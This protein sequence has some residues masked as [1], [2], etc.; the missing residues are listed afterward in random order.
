MQHSVHAL[1][2]TCPGREIL[3]PSVHGYSSNSCS[4]TR[5]SSPGS[6]PAARRA[7]ID[8]DLVEALLEVGQR[9]LVGDVVALEEQLDA[10]AGD[11]VGA[12]VLALTE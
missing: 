10:A 8:A 5:T 9:L 7:A 2:Y 3:P 12:V 1:L 11:P 4:P 6:K